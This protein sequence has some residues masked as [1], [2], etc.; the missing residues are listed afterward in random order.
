ML[1]GYKTYAVA[2]AML[3]MGLLG[4]ISP[5]SLNLISAFLANIGLPTSTATLLLVIGLV[6]AGLRKVTEA[7]KREEIAK[8]KLL[9]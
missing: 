3:L 1:E 9:K 5:E 6:M 4:N 7:E 8:E 2:L